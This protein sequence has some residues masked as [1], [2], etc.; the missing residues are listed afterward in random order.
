M[1]DLPTPEDI[2][3]Y[4]LVAFENRDDMWPSP[5]GIW[6]RFSDYEAERSRSE[7]RIKA[8]E[9]AVAFV[10]NSTLLDFTRNLT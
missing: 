5:D 1:T 6:V 3:R 8:L 4:N 9:E 10:R 7:E 2:K